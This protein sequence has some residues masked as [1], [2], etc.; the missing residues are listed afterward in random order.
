MSLRRSAAA[1]E[2]AAEKSSEKGR[3]GTRPGTPPSEGHATEADTSAAARRSGQAGGSAVPVR[4]RTARCAL[5]PRRVRLRAAP[6]RRPHAA[7]RR[8]RGRRSDVRTANR[9][10]EPAAATVNLRPSGGGTEPFADGFAH[11]SVV[12]TPQAA[13]DPRSPRAGRALHVR[14]GG[15]GRRLGS[16]RRL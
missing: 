3:A 11:V 12:K 7:G 9:A 2:R 15:E 5:F 10:L 8:V 14:A 4:G 13:R 16:A 1:R 6:E